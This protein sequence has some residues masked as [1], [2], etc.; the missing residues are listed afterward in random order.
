M[1]GIL[2]LVGS[3]FFSSPQC[4]HRLGEEDALSPG[5]KLPEREGD[6]SFPSSTEFS[7]G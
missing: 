7:N 4:P 2:F 6:H 3:R 1:T 5:V